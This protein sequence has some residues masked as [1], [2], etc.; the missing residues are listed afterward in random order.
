[1]FSPTGGDMVRSFGHPKFDRL[2]RENF[3]SLP[4]EIKKKAK[5]RKVLLLKV[6]FPKKVNGKMIT[7]SVD[8]YKNFIN[9]L[10]QYKNLF[11]IFMPHPKFYEQLEEVLGNEKLK[12]FKEVLD[13]A[14]N[15]IE[16]NDDD[17]RPV[18]MNC[19]YYIVDRSALMI[20]AAVTEKPILYVSTK[21]PE[22]MT[23]PVQKIVD[24]YYQATT[25]KELINFLDEIVIPDKDPLKEE[26]LSVFRSIIP[27]MK[28][29]SGFLIKED[30]VNSLKKE[31]PLNKEVIDK[32]FTDE[33]KPM[34]KELYT[35]KIPGAIIIKKLIKRKQ[36]ECKKKET[37]CKQK[38]RNAENKVKKH[39]SYRLGKAIVESFKTPLGVIKLPYSLWKAY[40][41]FKNKR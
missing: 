34:I 23:A 17:Y 31:K 5:D 8:M 3:P 26:R 18:L 29:K 32:K 14:D 38:V 4:E 25:G 41:D 15:V 20:E 27:D 16:Y 28:G 13:N 36:N 9:K 2:N 30:I 6:H 37:E 12:E 33:F 10:P 35:N 11:C 39:L 40:S 19:D 24:T 7:P 1:M 21:N 22:K